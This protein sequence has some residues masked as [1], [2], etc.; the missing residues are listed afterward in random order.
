MH[1]FVS[2]LGTVKSNGWMVNTM[3]LPHEIDHFGDSRIPYFE[4]KHRKCWRWSSPLQFINNVSMIHCSLTC[5]WLSTQWFSDDSCWIHSLSDEQRQLWKI[6]VC[7]L[8]HRR[9]W[10]SGLQL[11]TDFGDDKAI[12]QDLQTMIRTY[13]L[14]IYVY[15]YTRI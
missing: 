2:N 13:Y 3:R 10:V 4:A 14:Y 1:G 12:W 6:E 7:G 15:T 9:G 8:H 11:S 5:C